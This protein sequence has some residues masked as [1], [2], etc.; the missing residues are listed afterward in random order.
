MRAA[1][2]LC[3]ALAAS[4][5]SAGAG[6]CLHSG[7]AAAAAPFFCHHTVLLL[8]PPACADP[9]N[10]HGILL[11]LGDTKAPKI[12]EGETWESVVEVQRNEEQEEGFRSK[13]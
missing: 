11:Q 4:H 6:R 13:L 1:R 8:T 12:H 2:C 10:T 7:S 9:K 3:S 5:P